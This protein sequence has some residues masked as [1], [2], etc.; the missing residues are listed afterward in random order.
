MPVQDQRTAADAST[1]ITAEQVADHR[2]DSTL[3]G[4]RWSDGTAECRA[5][6][7]HPAGSL[8]AHPGDV[9]VVLTGDDVAC[10]H[11]SD[12]CAM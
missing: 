2:F 6:L 4:V 5:R 9:G 1:K 3:T 10:D 8:T 12:A 7:L 11:C